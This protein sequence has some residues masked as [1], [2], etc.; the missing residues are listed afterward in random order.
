MADCEWNKVPRR[1]RNSPG[2]APPP[3]EPLRLALGARQSLEPRA[4]ALR[5]PRCAL[6]QRRSVPQQRPQ[7]QRQQPQRRER[8]FDPQEMA[9]RGRI[10]AFRLHATHDPRETT[11]KARAA[12]DARFL[13]EVDPDGVLPEEE[14]RRRA[15]ARA[16]AG[17]PLPP[18]TPV[19]PPRPSPRFPPS[20]PNGRRRSP[21]QEV[22]TDG[23]GATG[24]TGPVALPGP[25]RQ[26]AG[27]WRTRRL[28]EEPTGMGNLRARAVYAGP[29]HTQD[30]RHPRAQADVPDVPGADVPAP[31]D[32]YQ[33]SG[34]LA[35][36]RHPPPPG[37]A[38][39]E[40]D[41]GW[42]G[43]DRGRRPRPAPPGG[44]WR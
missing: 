25:K 27:V 30:R 12:F 7:R 10:G 2:G 17:R 44:E 37:H 39:G 15:A 29:E 8:R 28:R 23:T 36:T 11:K 38:G 24:P 26:A 16:A 34:S 43:Q 31:G 33:R 41:A 19:P 21:L 5:L 9:L 3:D 4:A 32:R 22:A 40:P 20:R 6:S 14:R 18:T 42:G 13:R 35:H 1:R